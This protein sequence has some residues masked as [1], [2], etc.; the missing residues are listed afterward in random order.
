MK[1]RIGQ[2]EDLEA[3]QAFDC[4]G[5]DRAA[6]LAAGRCL[7]AELD[8]GIAGYVVF[9]PKGL[10]GQHFINF[11]VVDEPY[12]RQGVAVALLRAVE[13]QLLPCRLFISTGKTNTRMQALLTKDGWTSAGQI[14]G[15]MPGEFTELFYFRDVP[16][17][18][19]DAP[20]SD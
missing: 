16:E 3:I 6:D 5:G 4:F 19:S 10:I 9:S 15:M 1:T 11:L 8:R 7:V 20:E 17:A 18:G 2:P 12:R 13:K 14:A